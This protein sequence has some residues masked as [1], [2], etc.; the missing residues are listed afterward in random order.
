M[1]V[2]SAIVVNGPRFYTLAA[3]NPTEASWAT[4]L[5]S[6]STTK[7]PAALPECAPLA[8]V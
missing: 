7:D 2:M 5:E 8:G 3:N 4:L 6:F 1:H